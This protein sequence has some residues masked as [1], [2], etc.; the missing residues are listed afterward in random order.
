M[1]RSKNILFHPEDS[2]SQ[3]AFSARHPLLF[4]LAALSFLLMLLGSGC[5]YSNRLDLPPI[6]LAKTNQ[7]LSRDEKKSAVL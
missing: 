2:V 7:A 4:R 6:D 1:N 5:A 3:E